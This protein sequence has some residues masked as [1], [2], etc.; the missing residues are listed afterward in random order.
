VSTEMTTEEQRASNRAKQKRFHKR[1][2]EYHKQYAK[3]RK[4]ARICRETNQHIIAEYC[5]FELADP[6]DQSTKLI[7]FGKVATKPLWS[8][9][10][11]VKEYS[12]SQWA[13]WM[14]ELADLNLY[15]VAKNVIGVGVPLNQRCALIIM[16]LQQRRLNNYVTGNDLATPWWILR[17]QDPFYYVNTARVR[18][19]KACCPAGRVRD[20]VVERFSSYVEAARVTGSPS[21][22]IKHWVETVGTSDGWTWFDDR[23]I[24]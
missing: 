1:H 21:C 6:R 14:R 17:I 13:A 3:K 2:P 9:M 18:P 7:A 16:R 15:P 8:K 4:Y 23:G 22:M 11:S 20:G 5:V 10:W 19:T 24:L 12:R